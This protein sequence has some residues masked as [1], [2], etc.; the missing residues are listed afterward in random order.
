MG[1]GFGF[2]LGRRF[3]VGCAALAR[4][5]FTSAQATPTAEVEARIAPRRLSAQRSTSF[6]TERLDMIGQARQR[7]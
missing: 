5:C 4:C 1:F 2:E 7:I 3:G 6:R